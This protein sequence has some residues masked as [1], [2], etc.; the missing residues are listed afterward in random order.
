ERGFMNG[1]LIA[2]I[3][4]LVVV[5]GMAGLAA[6]LYMQYDDQRVNVNSK[7]DVAVADAKKEQ[8]D[9]YEEEFEKRE[10]EPDREFAGPEDYGRLSFMYPKKWSAYVAN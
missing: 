4:L 7:I 9:K 1:Q 2:I 3:G 5:V 10:N 6:W 8:A